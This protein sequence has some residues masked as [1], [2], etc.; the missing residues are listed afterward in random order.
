MITMRA[1]FSDSDRAILDQVHA[2]LAIVVYLAAEKSPIKINVIEG[3]RSERRQAELVRTGASKT[4]HS[5]HL[6]GH[7][8]DLAPMIDGHVRWDWPLFYPIAAA[9]RHAAIKLAVPIRWGG[10]WDRELSD[11]PD[12]ADAIQDAQSDYVSRE[13]LAGH[14]VFLDGPHFE[15]PRSAPGYA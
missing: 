4:M 2:Q 13:R 11:L 10:V 5:R 12:T 3:V 6:T 7:A 14:R 8:V 1:L 15:I 9:M